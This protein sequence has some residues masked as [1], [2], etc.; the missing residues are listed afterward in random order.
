MGLKDK[1]YTL[2]PNIIQNMMISMFNL[3]AYKN[4]YGKYYKYCFKLHSK[5]KSLSLKELKDLQKFK[6][7]EFISFAM[8]N[9]SFY[10]ILYQ[11]LLNQVPY[12]F[13][14]FFLCK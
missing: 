9:T 7:E 11:S 10:K 8:K 4:R 5:N 12:N 6:F 13:R 2:A 1:I 14:C 3:L